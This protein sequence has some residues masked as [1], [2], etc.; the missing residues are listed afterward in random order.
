MLQWQNILHFE[1]A[2][3]NPP[4]SYL[5]TTYSGGAPLPLRVNVRN[6]YVACVATRVCLHSLRKSG[7]CHSCRGQFKQ[8]PNGVC[9]VQP[10]ST[11]HSTKAECEHPKA[12]PVQRRNR[13]KPQTDHL[14][15]QF[16]MLKDVS[17]NE[18]SKPKS[19][20]SQNVSC[21]WSAL[22]CTSD[23]LQRCFT[24]SPSIETD[25]AGT[26]GTGGTGTSKTLW[27]LT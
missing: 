26:G 8:V 9:T 21:V 5:E 23:V 22:V 3:L 6:M 2:R 18:C 17:W 25:K 10:I 14:I 1:T 27:R 11:L 16:K 24:I 12:N 7:Q 20:V 13:T 15:I 4:K 19:S